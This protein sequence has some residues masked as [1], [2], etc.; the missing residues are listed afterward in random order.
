MSDNKINTDTILEPVC[1]DCRY[2]ISWPKCFAFPAGIPE[3]IR[4]GTNRH[5]K[6]VDGDIG[7]TFKPALPG[8]K[9]P[10]IEEVFGDI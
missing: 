6:P 8:G 4:N 5:D 9:L 3:D 2:L 10:P 7:L 1:Y